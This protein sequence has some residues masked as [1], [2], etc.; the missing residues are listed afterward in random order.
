[1]RRG[2]RRKKNIKSQKNEYSCIVVDQK[3]F[4]DGK[5]L[6]TH[7]NH[8]AH[9]LTVFFYCIF[10]NSFSLAN[11]MQIRGINNEID[12]E[13]IKFNFVGKFKANSETKM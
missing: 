5:Q 10:Q 1:M 6:K 13:K 7:K 12:T 3:C 8:Q 11:I 9:L 2:N 4:T